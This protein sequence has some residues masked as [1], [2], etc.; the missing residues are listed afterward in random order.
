MLEEINSRFPVSHEKKLIRHLLAEYEKQGENGRPIVE[1]SDVILVNFSLS[2]I[3]I[4]DVDEKNQVL[5]TSVWYQ[6]VSHCA[7]NVKFRNMQVSQ[8][9][10]SHAP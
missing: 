5:K 10:I 7:F 6:Y 4:M 8:I 9:S 3:Q 2:L 1:L